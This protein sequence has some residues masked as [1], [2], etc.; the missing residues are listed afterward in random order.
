[1]KGVRRRTTDFKSHPGLGKPLILVFPPNPNFLVGKNPND[2]A[3]MTFAGDH[4]ISASCEGARSFPG[5]YCAE[6]SSQP[7]T[8]RRLAIG[9]S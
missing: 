8:F 4:A 9:S 5:R 1:M 7:E 3:Q 6:L 2:A